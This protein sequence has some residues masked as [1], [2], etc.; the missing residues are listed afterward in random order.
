MPAAIGACGT[1]VAAVAA[2]FAASA[3]KSDPTPAVV[4]TFTPAPTS[5]GATA[6]PEPT[7]TLTPA[8]HS[9]VAGNWDFRYTVLSNNCPFGTSEGG[10]IDYSL[11]IQERYPGD[12]Y[13]DEGDDAEVLDQGV[14]LGYIEL[15]YPEFGF[16]Y[17]IAANGY[18]GTA[19]VHITFEDSES[20]HGFRKDTYNDGAG[21]QCSIV[22]EDH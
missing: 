5:A 18:T 21:N 19:D 3:V 7:T 17:P 10:R 16:Q 6:T 8:P 13:I 12:G 15:T 20:G 11:T 1:V 4:N 14:H 9:I 22:A 2:V